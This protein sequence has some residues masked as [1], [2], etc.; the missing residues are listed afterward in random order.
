M[1]DEGKGV[2]FK[3]RRLQSHTLVNTEEQIMKEMKNIIQREKIKHKW[4]EDAAVNYTF[5]FWI[6]E[7]KTKNSDSEKSPHALSVK[8]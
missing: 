8:T 5:C 7:T 1:E 6:A 2:T 4:R 3:W